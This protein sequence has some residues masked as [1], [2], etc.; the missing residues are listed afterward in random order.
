MHV[1][2]VTISMDILDRKLCCNNIIKSVPTTGNAS[3][4]DEYIAR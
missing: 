1:R 2:S 3:F 4:V